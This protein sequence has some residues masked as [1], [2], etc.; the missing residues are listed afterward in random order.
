MKVTECSFVKKCSSQGTGPIPASGAEDRTH[1][2]T[3]LH[4]GLDLIPQVPGTGPHP[5]YRAHTTTTK[6]GQTT[7]T[8]VFGLRLGQSS[9]QLQPDVLL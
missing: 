9:I 8:I 6:T 3:A 1:I 2:L 4:S 5:H 7:T